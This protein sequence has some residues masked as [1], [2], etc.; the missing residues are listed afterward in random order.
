[1]LESDTF[2]RK[3]DGRKFFKNT[4]RPSCRTPNCIHSHTGQVQGIGISYRPQGETKTRSIVRV[5]L[6]ARS[7]F[8]SIANSNRQVSQRQDRQVS[9]A[10]FCPNLIHRQPWEC[11]S[12]LYI[13]RHVD[14]LELS[15]GVEHE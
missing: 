15:W 1:M 9:E 12:L 4:C 6:Q 14:G 8:Q 10:A 11:F 5:V 13:L 2:K 3:K 7:S